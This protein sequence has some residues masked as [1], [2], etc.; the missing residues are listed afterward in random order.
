M[1]K[2][3]KKT[4]YG[5]TRE[6]ER[7]ASRFFGRHVSAPK[8][9]ALFVASVLCCALPM[10]LGL[11]LWDGIPEIVKTGIITLEGEDDSMPRAVLVFGVPGL[12]VLLDL[13]CH[14]QLWIHQKREELP[15][16]AAR[17]IGRWGIPVV[18]TL[19]CP[20]WI[21]RAAGEPV[22]G[23]PFCALGLLLLLTGAHFFDCPRGE[24][25][26]FRLKPIL[27]KEEAWQK[28]HR[29][30]GLCWMLA[31]LLVMA[32]FYGLGRLPGWS[33]AILLLLLLAPIPAASVFGKN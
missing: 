3:K 11:R 24:S 31:G 29:F 4:T 25:F 14:G 21:Q 33:A 23:Y 9:L 1:D 17:L 5:L 30:A 28:T 27:Y 7:E 18:G 8:A 16:K 10:L 12:F 22:T 19:L 20:F 26:A 6:Q 15:P 32:L 13:I 2:P